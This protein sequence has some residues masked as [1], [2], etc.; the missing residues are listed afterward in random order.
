LSNEVKQKLGEAR[1]DSLARAGRIP[2]VTPA[3][4]SLLLVYLKKKGVLSHP[5]SSLKSA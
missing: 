5:D 3:A 4:V 2:G 1:P